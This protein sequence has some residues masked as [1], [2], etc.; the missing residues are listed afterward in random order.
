MYVCL[1]IDLRGYLSEDLYVYS[2]WNV[3]CPVLCVPGRESLQILS[4]HSIWCSTIL[5]NNTHNIFYFFYLWVFTAPY[6]VCWQNLKRFANTHITRHD[7][8]HPLFM[9]CTALYCVCSYF[10]I[11]ERQRCLGSPLV[12]STLFFEKEPYDSDLFCITCTALHCVC[13]YIMN[14]KW[15]QCIGSLLF[16]KTA[17]WPRA[18]LRWFRRGGGHNRLPPLRSQ[19]RR[20]TLPFEFWGFRICLGFYFFEKVAL[21]DTLQRRYD[22]DFNPWLILRCPAE[23]LYIIVEGMVRL[24]KDSADLQHST[25]IEYEQCVCVRVCVHAVYGPGD[26]RPKQVIWVRSV[27][28]SVSV[29]GYER[30]MKCSTRFHRWMHRWTQ[31]DLRIFTQSTCVHV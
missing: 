31:M 9:T 23:D 30:K 14:T 16:C 19:E 22:A 28:R 18:L 3:Y 27:V 26:W 11:M 15:Q 6:W 4:T 5:I 12:L 17:L 13:S 24:H 21:F 25:T 1:C 29:F 2:H 20:E 8:C 10:M 7:S